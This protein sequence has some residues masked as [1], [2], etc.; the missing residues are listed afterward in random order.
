MFNG[1]RTSTGANLGP[2]RVALGAEAWTEASFRGGSATQIELLGPFL[3]LKAQQ[4]A[5]TVTHADGT[6]SASVE[7]FPVAVTGQ[8]TVNLT[9]AVD[10]VAHLRKHETVLCVWGYSVVLKYSP[11]NGPKCGPILTD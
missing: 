4:V 6:V 3:Q 5:L 8:Q 7:L 11:K 10:D 1:N 2:I 9:L